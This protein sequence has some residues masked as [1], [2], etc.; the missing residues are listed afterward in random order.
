[1]N[2][3]YFNADFK[4]QYLDDN[5]SRNIHIKVT[6]DLLFRRI[7][8]TENELG[9]D[10]YDFTVAEILGY[11]KYLCTP[12][13]ES[14]M[15]MNNQYKLYTAY[16]L[17]KGLVKDNQNHYAEIDNKT[18]MTC[19]HSGLAKAKVITR[20]NLLE[21]LESGSVENISDKVIALALFEGVCGKELTELTHLE[22]TD[23][24]EK[25]KVAKLYGGR[26]LELS[27]KLVAWCL[28]SADEYEYYNSLNVKGNKSYLQTDTRVI[29]R[30][31]NS[32]VDTDLQRHKTINRRLD[33]LIDCTGCNAFTVGA[34]R[35]SGR[36][37]MI[38]GLMDNGKPL[39][40][41]L[42]DKDMVYRYGK[43][44]S[45]KRYCMKYGLD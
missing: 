43:I 13:F 19:V 18:L 21:I 39:N 10:L 20:E 14:L 8:E 5:E 3:K 11:Y 2:N 42:T 7:S 9:K 25:T 31:S 12:S 26:E 32:T 34:L 17:K 6:V 16:A 40:V 24:N 4:K 33:H 29:K 37:E 36:L 35:E 27:D 38:K 28:E 44:P 45:L 22:P 30:L 23:L 41:A 1:M 15:I